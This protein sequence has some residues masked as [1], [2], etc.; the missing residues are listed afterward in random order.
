MRRPLVAL[1]AL[2]TLAATG[3][4]PVGAQAVAPA[5]APAADRA[6]PVAV[7]DVVVTGTGASTWPAFDPTVERY[8]VS[9]TGETAGALTVTATTSDPAGTVT[10]DGR[11][12]PGGT[13][14]VDGLEAGDEVAVMIDDAE[15]HAAYSFVYLPEEFPTLQRVT[16]ASSAPTYEHVMLTLGLWLSPSPFFETAIDANGVPAMVEATDGSMD[17]KRQ[18]NGHYSVQ[19]INAANP[20]YPDSEVVE[21]DE[22]FRKVGSY[23]AT[24]L[25]HTDGHD[26]ILLPDGSR[27]F[28]S[29]EPNPVTGLLDARIQHESGTGQVL[30]EWTSAPYADETMSPAGT[31]D[32]AHINSFVITQDDNLLV[33]FRNLSAVFKISRTTGEVLWRLGGRASSFDF[34]T[35]AGDPDD[36][37]GPCAQHTASELPDGNILVFDNGAWSQAQNLCVDPA[38]SN[39]PAVERLPTRIVEWAVDEEAGTATLVREHTVDQRH[40]IFAGSAQ[41]LPD[42]RSMVGW[43]SER[44]AVASELDADGD[45]VWEVRDAAPAPGDRYF[46]YRAHATDVPDAIRPVVSLDPLAGGATYV[47]GQAVATPTFSCTDRGGSSL[48]TCSATQVDTRTPGRRAVVVTATDA[49]GNVTTARRSYLVVHRY[50]PGLTARATHVVTHGAGPAVAVLRVR[51]EGRVADRFTLR[52]SG[53]TA[54]WKVRLAA[55]TSPTLAPGATWTVRLRIT[56]RAKAVPGNRVRVRVEATS[57]GRADRTDAVVV[58]ARLARP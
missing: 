29:Y 24:G 35:A 58:R 38:D 57:R 4:V 48:Q 51:N 54:R 26:S 45:V 37:G 31:A 3:S 23:R 33:S 21:L 44:G 1:A 19:R 42:G 15:G 18:P 40:A 8:A 11:P 34:L 22:Q 30:W 14:T 47:E 56:A 39:A 2:A 13:T 9:T 55:R 49:D 16:P 50:L 12:A 46:T 5:V 25:S 43:A 28:M 17:L 52:S 7:H 41:G 10:V 36:D 27:Y 53:P 32:Y 20:A 6:D